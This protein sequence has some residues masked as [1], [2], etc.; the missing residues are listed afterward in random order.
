M[1]YQEVAKHSKELEGAL[2]LNEAADRFDDERE[3]N[4]D[5]VNQYV[6]KFADIADLDQNYIHG[7]ENS[8]AFSKFAEAIKNKTNKKYVMIKVKKG[9]KK[10]FSRVPTV[11]VQAIKKEEKKI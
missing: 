1:L 9:M 11:E 8:T 7:S 4:E 3:M 6:K 2:T 5:K 10:S